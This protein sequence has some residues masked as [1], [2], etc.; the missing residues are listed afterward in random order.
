MLDQRDFVPIADGL[1]AGTA[2]Q[3]E[4]VGSRCRT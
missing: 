1:I 2:A 3:P 4:L